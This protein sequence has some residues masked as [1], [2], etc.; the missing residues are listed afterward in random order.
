M[1]AS[2]KHIPILPKKPEP[3]LSGY[4]ILLIAGPAVQSAPRRV[5]AVNTNCAQGYLTADVYG[6]VRDG[7]IEDMRVVVGGEDLYNLLPE[8]ILQEITAYVIGDQ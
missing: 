1:N 2:V 5:T 7:V 6:S 3:L 8:Q 4:E